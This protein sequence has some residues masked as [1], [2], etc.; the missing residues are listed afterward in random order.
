M[1][2]ELLQEYPHLKNATVSSYEIT[3]EVSDQPKSLDETIQ[4]AMNRAKGVFEK[5]GDYGFGKGGILESGGL[6]QPVDKNHTK[7]SM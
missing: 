6:I 7:S 5:G 4:G 1:V 3:S 2:Q